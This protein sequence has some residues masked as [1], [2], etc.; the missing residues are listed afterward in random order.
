[1]DA[2]SA[3]EKTDHCHCI[4][5]SID[6]VQNFDC[7]SCVVANRYWDEM[8]TQVLVSLKKKAKPEHDNIEFVN[9]HLY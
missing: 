7:V 8:R 6:C 5:E 1:M 2:I 4:Y 3:H 9:T